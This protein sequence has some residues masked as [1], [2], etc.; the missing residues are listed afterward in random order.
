MDNKK[1]VVSVAYTGKDEYAEN[2]ASEVPVGTV[3][4]KAMHQFEIEASA[5]ERYVLQLNG[6][7]IDDKT[8]I[9]DLGGA[10]IKLTLLLKKP[11]EKGYAR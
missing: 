10:D 9:G 3:K 11:Q 2:F 6:V 1:I 8:K 7:N 5:A 4:R